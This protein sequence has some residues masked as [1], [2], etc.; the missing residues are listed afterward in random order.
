MVR[1][2][3]IL[4]VRVGG[5]LSVRFPEVDRGYRTFKSLQ[6]TQ[7]SDYAKR[8]RMYAENLIGRRAEW[9]SNFL[10]VIHVR[11][12][13]IYKEHTESGCGRV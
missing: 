12:L 3:T 11:A 4:Y 1:R 9:E 7:M 10:V 8:K 5:L 6:L 13:S 2:V